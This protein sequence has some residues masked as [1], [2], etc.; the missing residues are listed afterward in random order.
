MIACN[1]SLPKCC[2]RGKGDTEPL[3][4]GENRPFF[5]LSHFVRLAKSLMEF[6]GHFVSLAKPPKT[7]HPPTLSA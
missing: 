3:S 2:S 4:H 5:L 1:V 6:P 7:L